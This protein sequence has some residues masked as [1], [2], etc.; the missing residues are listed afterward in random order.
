[1]RYAAWQSR[2]LGLFNFNTRGRFFY[3]FQN[4]NKTIIKCTTTINIEIA[5]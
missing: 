4:V 5:Q 2:P 3:F 1:M